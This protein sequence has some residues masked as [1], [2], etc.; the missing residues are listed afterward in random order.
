M[1]QSILTSYVAVAFVATVCLVVMAFFLGMFPV[2]VGKASLANQCVI[3]QS[4]YD[5][6]LGLQEEYCRVSFDRDRCYIHSGEALR[7]RNF[8]DSTCQKSGCPSFP[9]RC[10]YSERRTASWVEQCV[11]GSWGYYQS[12]PGDCLNG[13]CVVQGAV[14]LSSFPFGLIRDTQFDSRIVVGFSASDTYAAN[15]IA[16]SLAAVSVLRDDAIVSVDEELG[17]KDNYILVG[18]P[19]SNPTIFALYSQ[20][21]TAESDCL[22]AHGLGE[23]QGLIS[24]I[25]LNGVNYIIVTGYDDAAVRLAARVLANYQDYDLNTDKLC[26]T[27]TS[28]SDLEIYEG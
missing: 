24:A 13:L 10:H 22:S 20:I 8:L 27:G 17:A 11:S 18:T 25:H 16:R 6:Q 15:E 23:N 5:E 12:C 21:S 9:Y 4:L 2:S 3:A 14:S 1:R 19:C 28:L 7:Y 26:I